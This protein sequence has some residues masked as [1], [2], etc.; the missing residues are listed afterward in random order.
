M[1]TAPTLVEQGPA[2]P[3]TVPRVVAGTAAGPAPPLLGAPVPTRHGRALAAGLVAKRSRRSA[4]GSAAAS[5]VLVETA[6]RHAQSPAWPAPPPRAP[7]R[8][9]ACPVHPGRRKHARR[10]RPAAPVCRPMAPAR[11]DRPAGRAPA[12]P[13][14]VSPHGHLVDAGPR[15]RGR[16]RQK[17]FRARGP[18]GP[19]SARRRGPPNSKKPASNH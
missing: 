4:S 6:T 16:L 10:R 2:R 18:L 5:T 3:S 11:T 13:P 15:P 7:R 8:S 9:G 17:S 19:R 1:A 12:D 14:S